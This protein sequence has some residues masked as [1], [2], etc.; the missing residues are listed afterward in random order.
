[1]NP[2]IHFPSSFPILNTDRLSLTLP[3]L[4]DAKDLFNLRSDPEFMKYLGRYPMT[5]VSEAE[6]YIQRI[7][8]QFE[9]KQG[10]SWKISK[11]GSDHFMG[12][13][14][15]WKIEFEH[16]RTEIGYGIDAKYQGKGFMKEALNKL[17]QYAFKELNL[18]SIK[19][20]TDPLNIASK[21]L[22][23]AC[24][25]RKEAH[26]RENYFFDGKFIDSEYYGIIASDI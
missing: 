1:M 14:G 21:Q 25:F 2:I 7:H 5:K 23:L 8:D 15:F 3:Q 4:T 10:I 9:A 16:Y 19:A 26:I 18:H 17:T 12:Y 20:D 13:I 11:K 22:L 24:G 6:D